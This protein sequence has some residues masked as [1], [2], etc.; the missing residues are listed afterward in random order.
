MHNRLIAALCMTALLA[1]ACNMKKMAVN[2]VADMMAT[3]G[4]T[5]T[6]DPDPD[7]IKEAIPFGLK[8]MESLLAQSPN[9]PTLLLGLAS[10]FTQYAY[11]S[12]QDEADEIEPKD[13]AKAK[14]L[15]LRARNL[16]FR[17]KEYGMRGLEVA[18]R[19]MR[20]RIEDTAGDPKAALAKA[21]KKDVP[22]LY[23]TGM[24][25]AGAI[26]LDK[27]NAAL[28]AQLPTAIALVERAAELDEAYDYGALHEFFVQYD[29]RPAAMGGSLKRARQHF[30]RAVQL[31]GGYK[32][33]PYVAMAENVCVAEQ[34]RDEFLRMLDK[35]LSVDPNS[36]PEWRMLNMV[37][38]KKAR[39]LKARVADY[40]P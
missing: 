10:G 6:S 35:A 37:A 30:D 39:R 27:S 4:P 31:S 17:A 14:E 11:F 9:H 12:V 33:S 23:W 7:L 25:W 5:F 20:A 26:S 19:G 40:F 8:T 22:L 21:K 29:S 3:P 18:H 16:Y 15:R 2:S 24:G 1:G 38:Q 36:K 34:K 13:F 32:A 28:M